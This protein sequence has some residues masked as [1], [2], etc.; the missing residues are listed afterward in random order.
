[1]KIEQQ[2]LL[3]SFLSRGEGDEEELC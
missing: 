3:K 2:N 1:M